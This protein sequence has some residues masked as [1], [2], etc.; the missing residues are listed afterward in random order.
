LWYST[1]RFSTRSFML[2]CTWPN[3]THWKSFTVLLIVSEITSKSSFIISVSSKLTSIS[4]A[5]YVTHFSSFVLSSF[6]RKH[7]V[8]SFV[9][10]SLSTL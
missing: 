10:R 9:T 1:F 6:F 7:G 4:F 5:S 3:K 8:P 2:S